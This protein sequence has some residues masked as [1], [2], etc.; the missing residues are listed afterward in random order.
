MN[1]ENN[2][3]VAEQLALSTYLGISI[4][5]R[6]QRNSTVL[7]PSKIKFLLHNI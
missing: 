6:R 2:V 7:N 5:D 1:Q 4:A 3:N